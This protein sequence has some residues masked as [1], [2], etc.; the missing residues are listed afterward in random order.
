MSN[1][2]I[3]AMINARRLELG[4]TLEEVGNAVGVG[5]ST[6]RKWESGQIKNMGRDKVAALAKVLDLNPA[7]LIQSDYVDER[8][9]MN[10]EQRILF[11]LAKN[12]KPEAIRAAV[13][14]LKSMEGEDNDI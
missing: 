13:A 14:V 6:V 10:E 2:N 1:E 11:R 4:L 7:M 12:A 5:K 9:E 8:E 3:G